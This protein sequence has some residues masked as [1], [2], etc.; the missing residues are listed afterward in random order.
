MG[1]TFLD[2]GDLLIGLLTQRKVNIV[3]TE[4]SEGTWTASPATAHDLPRQFSTA[5]IWM[6]STTNCEARM[7]GT[8][9]L[10]RHCSPN[11]S[12]SVGEAGFVTDQ[13]F[14]WDADAG[15]ERTRSACIGPSKRKRGKKK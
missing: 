5:G 14:R 4:P 12:R 2:L 11:R 3:S 1:H 9:W 10:S 8:S 6:N 15:N 13:D 7:T